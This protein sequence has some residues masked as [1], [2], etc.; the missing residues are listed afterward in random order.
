[1]LIA[2]H[3][4]DG[5]QYEALAEALDPDSRESLVDSL[6]VQAD[7]LTKALRPF[8]SPEAP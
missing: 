3:Y 5:V 4:L 6:I 1:M 7:A 8:C 2:A